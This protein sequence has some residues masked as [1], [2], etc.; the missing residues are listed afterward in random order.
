[1]NTYTNPGDLVLDNV[2]GSGTLPVACLNTGRHYIGIEKDAAYFDIA[3]T[4]VRTRETEIA[5]TLDL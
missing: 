2:M 1:M 5:Y 4:R 3:V